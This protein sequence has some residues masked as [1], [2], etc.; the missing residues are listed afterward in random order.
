VT[1]W[2]LEFASDEG[3]RGL[4]RLEVAPGN[5]PA[6][7]WTYLI[8][9]PEIVGIIAVRDDDVPPPRQGL[10]IRADGLWAELWCEQP[11][12]HWTFGL[13]AFGLRVDAVDEQMGDRV[14]VG[15]DLE[16][17][18]GPDGPPHGLVHGDVLVERDRFAVA[19]RGSFLEGD[20]PPADDAALER[21]VGGGR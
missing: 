17:E 18:V 8:G 11:H 3:V 14:A 13:E 10:E 9:L 12:E 15:L 1:G 2:Q 6:R 16:W 7:Y 20:A 19:A 5:L 4:V 21:W